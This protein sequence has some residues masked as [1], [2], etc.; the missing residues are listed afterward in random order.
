MT[1]TVRELDLVDAVEPSQPT[2][3]HHLAVLVDS[4]LVRRERRGTRS[5]VAVG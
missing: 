1:P 5:G 4:G 3:R 2:V